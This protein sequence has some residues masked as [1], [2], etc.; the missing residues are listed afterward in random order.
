MSVKSHDWNEVCRV[1]GPMVWATVYRILDDH[2]DALDCY[3]EVF[4]EA[5]QRTCQQGVNNWPALL[6]WLGTRRAID[7][8]RRRKR[9]KSLQVS[10]LEAIDLASVHAHPS[11]L[12]QLQ[13]L[14]DRLKLELAN[15][16]NRQGE[17]F[18]LR[19]IEQLTYVEIAEQ[20]ETDTR[21]VGVLIHRARQSLQI[22]LTEFSTS[23]I[24]EPS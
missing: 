24:Q 21:E 10:S 16:P 17:A 12:V 9:E 4:L 3:Q 15:L 1:H 18:W 23:P 20:M 19:S 8:L 6:K 22:A 2:A 5:Y 11:H 13:E 7:A 14:I